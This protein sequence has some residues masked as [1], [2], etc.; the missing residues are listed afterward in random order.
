MTGISL[1]A[2]EVSLLGLR[3]LRDWSSLSAK[4]PVP[5]SSLQKVLSTPPQ[6]RLDT[7]ESKVW[8]LADGDLSIATTAERLGLSIEK[9]RQIAFRL[10]AT[11]ILREIPQPYIHQPIEIPTPDTTSD[12][13]PTNS[14]STSFLGKLIGFLKQKA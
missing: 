5:E 7:Q 6:L 3:M 11:G 8:N 4:L 1:T 2:Q 12:V 9:V 13:K 14:I 10:C